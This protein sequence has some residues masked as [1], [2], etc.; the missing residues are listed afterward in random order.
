[1]NETKH[2]TSKCPD[3]NSPGVMIGGFEASG[4]S[5]TEYQCSECNR[6]WTVAE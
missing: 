6:E 4:C 3:C 1:M 2:F 5:F